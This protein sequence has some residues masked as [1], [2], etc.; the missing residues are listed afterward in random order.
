MAQEVIQSPIP[1]ID[2]ALMGRR[3]IGTVYGGPAESP[4]RILL[5]FDNGTAVSFP[6]SGLPHFVPANRNIQIP[7]AGLELL[8]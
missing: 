8:G 1:A 7:Q 5:E 3:I 2:E 6:L 4:A